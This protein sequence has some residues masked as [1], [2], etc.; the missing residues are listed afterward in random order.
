MDPIVAA[1]TNKTLMNQQTNVYTPYDS[2]NMSICFDSS[3]HAL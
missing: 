3:I 1:Y 2:P